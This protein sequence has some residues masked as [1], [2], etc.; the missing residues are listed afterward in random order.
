[1]RNSNGLRRPGSAATD[2]A[3]VACGRYDAFYEYGLNA[4]DVAAG[5]LLVLEAGGEVSDFEGVKSPLFGG[6]DNDPEGKEPLFGGEII[7][8]NR[9]N[10]NEFQEAILKI[11]KP[12]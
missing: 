11:M 10:Y 2:I 7:C 1:M 5:A 4:W 9:K 3:Y 12:Q 6:A 8:A